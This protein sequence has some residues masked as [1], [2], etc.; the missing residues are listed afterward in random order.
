LVSALLSADGDD[1][2]L[3]DLSCWSSHVIDPLLLGFSIALRR[4]R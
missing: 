2:G 1:A 3:C 4:W